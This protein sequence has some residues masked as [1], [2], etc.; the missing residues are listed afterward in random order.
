M[1]TNATCFSVPTL[2]FDEEEEAKEHER[3]RQGQR[4]KER[5]NEIKE[6]EKRQRRYFH[7]VKIQLDP[8]E[9]RKRTLSNFF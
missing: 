1:S 5:M 2:T 4:E 8:W 3:Y 9:R 6:E 7:D